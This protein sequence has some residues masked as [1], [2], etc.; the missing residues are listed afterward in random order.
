MESTSVPRV[1]IPKYALDHLMDTQGLLRNE[2]SRVFMIPE[3]ETQDW[4]KYALDWWNNQTPENEHTLREILQIMAAPSHLAY[5]TVCISDTMIQEANAAFS[6]PLLTEPAVIVGE[7]PEG[8]NY[9]VK[10]MVEGNV[11][12]NTIMMYLDA[13]SDI[14]TTDLAVE[15]SHLDLAVLLATVDLYK[16]KHMLSLMEHLEVDDILTYDDID[17]S[18]Q[19]SLISNDPRWVTS[20]VLDYLG[21]NEVESASVYDSAQN[22]FTQGWMRM[23]EDQKA[24]SFTDHGILLAES[25]RN[26]V[27]TVGLRTL[28]STMEGKV[29]SNKLVFIRGSQLLWFIEIQ[30]QKAVLTSINLDQAVE[31]VTSVLTPD[32]IPDSAPVSADPVC[33]KCGTPATFVEEYQRW[34]CYECKEYIQ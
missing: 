13:H 10:H 32:T 23:S 1:N 6:S 14:A 2:L 25:I 34:Y 33:K 4:K 7:A 15:M 20:F 12:A 11:F 9:E 26:K 28:A 30:P 22:L 3:T 8:D 18:L 5:M 27:N 29:G 31:I 24:F 21:I 19:N 16:R 17:K